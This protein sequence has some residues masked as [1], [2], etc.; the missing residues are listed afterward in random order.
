M[1]TFI[2][3]YFLVS[4]LF[5]SVYYTACDKQEDPE[6]VVVAR[7]GN[8]IITVSDFRRSYEFGFAHLKKEPD[9]K[10]SYLD[11][12]IKEKVLALEGYKLGL[13]KNERVRKLEEKLRDELLIE[14]LF[15]S[16]VNSKIKITPDQVREAINKSKVSWKLRYWMEPTLDY[17]QR[18][19]QA[20]RERGYADVVG[21]ILASNPETNLKP[22]DFETKY[23]SFL[24]VTDEFLDAIKDLPIG[25]ISDP[26]ERNGVYFIYQIVDVR[27]DPVTENEY[28]D[29]YE[30][31][32]Q[33]LY[34]RQLKKEAVKYVSNYM[35]PKNVT[36][37]GDAFRLLADALSEWRR[38]TPDDGDFMQAVQ[39]AAGEQS[40]MK[41][42]RDNLNLTLVTFS[43]GK[44]TIAD[45]L[46]RFDPLSIKADP[47]ERR[48]VRSQLNDKIALTVRNYFL[49]KEAKKK[50]L[51]K[52]PDLQKELKE[53]RDKWVYKE[54]R[55]YYTQDIKVSEDEVKAYFEKYKDR[56]KIRWDDELTFEEFKNQAHRDA[57][58]RRVKARLDRKVDSLSAYFPIVVNQAVLDT[59][60]TIEFE[61]SR[62]AAM[63]VFKNSSKRLA[64]PIVDP[65]WGF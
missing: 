9:R 23:L 63:P 34:Y 4:I 46:E 10:R 55:K 12:M 17:A 20:M 41:K 3:K 24:D 2:K 59:I 35:T 15:K 28:Q 65:A 57:A 30:K 42:L 43:G 13:D 38:Q 29:Q 54:T 18:V 1:M 31:Y 7:V 45:F 53:W 16:Q 26:V 44:W 22:K 49:I 33:I 36:T 52:S 39:N 19:A 56:Y 5:L 51:L 47:K 60:T 50:G 61:K 40:A 8:D 6:Q 14:E 58:I 37:K 64:A 25:E 27:R 32:R 21:E 62:W 11:Y 48:D